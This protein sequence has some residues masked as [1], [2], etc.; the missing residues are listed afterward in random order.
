LRVNQDY[1]AVT[2]LSVEKDSAREVARVARVMTDL[3]FIRRVPKSRLTERKTDAFLN[4][5]RALNPGEVR[6]AIAEP[7][8]NVAAQTGSRPRVLGAVP[9][10]DDAKGN[11]FGLVMI[12]TDATAEAERILG[13]DIGGD[14]D[15]YI[16]DGHG[17][18]WLSSRAGRSDQIESGKENVTSFVPSTKEFFNPG[19]VESTLIA[20]EQGVIGY[21]IRLNPFDPA[22]SVGVVL[23]LA[24]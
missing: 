3:S 13:R 17:Q 2:Y 10:Y 16:T 7:D 8:A 18:I 11:V 12:E 6:L 1:L 19:N 9:V 4:L 22:G 14:A 23:R 15:I 5:V 21:R 24:D 20:P